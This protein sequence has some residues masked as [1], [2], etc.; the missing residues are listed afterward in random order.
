MMLKCK[1]LILA[2]AYLIVLP[3]LLRSVDVQ[4]LMY[5]S[6]P[7]L[8]F[9]VI[10]DK[11]RTWALQGLFFLGELFRIG[12]F[13]KQRVGFWFGCCVRSCFGS[14]ADTGLVRR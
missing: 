7:L 4:I 8:V 2:M 3:G 6:V 1:V 13:T 5:G 14:A 9:V 10:E 11:S 12:M